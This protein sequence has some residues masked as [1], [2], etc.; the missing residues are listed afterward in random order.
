MVDDVEFILSFAKSR[1]YMF[2]N[3]QKSNIFEQ[4]YRGYYMF[5]KLAIYITLSASVAKS[6][7]PI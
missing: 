1:M 3:N 2:K 5:S 7:Q 4:E 6:H